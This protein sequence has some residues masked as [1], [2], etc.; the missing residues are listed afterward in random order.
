VTNESV[1]N[2]NFSTLS[3]FAGVSGAGASAEEYQIELVPTDGKTFLQGSRG[4]VVPAEGCLYYDQK[5]EN[6][7]AELLEVIVHEYGHLVLHHDQF[8][9]ATQDLVRG[10]AF[11]NTGAPALSRYSPRSQQEAEASAF[12]AEFICPARE[13]LDV[14]STRK[15]AP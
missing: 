7:K 8:G 12:A 5:L 6:H 11:L 2:E 10:S 9:G 1:T 15:Q 3:R 14:G 13:S 4:E